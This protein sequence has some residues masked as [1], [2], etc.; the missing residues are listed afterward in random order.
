MKL[1]I[2]FITL[3]IPVFLNAQND[4]LK[5]LLNRGDI[6]KLQSYYTKG[7][8]LENYVTISEKNDT[9]MVRVHPIVY[10]VK[11][12]NVNLIKYYLELFQNSEKGFSGFQKE[13]SEAFIYSLSKDNEEISELLL[14]CNVGK[15][16]E[17]SL[18]NNYSALM[19]AATYGKEKW[20]F[21]L[22]E[23]N[24]EVSK[25]SNGNNLLHCAAYGGSVPIVKDVLAMKIFDVNEANNDHQTSFYLSFRHESKE[26]FD[27]LLQAGGECNTNEY[28]WFSASEIVNS[29]IK[30]FIFNF[31][32]IE[33]LFTPNEYYELP[34]YQAI[35]KN[36]EMMIYSMLDEMVKH[37]DLIKTIP[38]QCLDGNYVYFPLYSALENNN[39]FVY[40]AWLSFVSQIYLCHGDF[41]KV[42]MYKDYKKNAS[43]TFGRSYVNNRYDEY[44]YSVFY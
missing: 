39:K 24:F 6:N 42:P 10:A 3:L 5:Q 21:R 18:C 23:L 7:N 8:L 16:M 37:C 31:T 15:S 29:D 4:D 30:N 26:V 12:Q 41:S 44:F 25:P 2:A 38:E 36:N 28:A 33:Y 9:P 19:T 32:K 43:K 27:I 17:C 13:I 1:T 14:G 22:K 11:L 40:E 34:V 35:Y 20:Y